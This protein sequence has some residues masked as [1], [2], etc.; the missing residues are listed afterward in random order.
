MGIAVNAGEVI[1]GNIGSDARAKYGIVG[2][3]VNIT[4]R[5]QAVAGPNQV[6]LSESVW[7]RARQEILVERLP[8]VELKGVQQPIQLYLLKG[9]KEGLNCQVG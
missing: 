2:A 8:H 1:V 5:I 9:H 6:I 7:L 3:P 4:Q